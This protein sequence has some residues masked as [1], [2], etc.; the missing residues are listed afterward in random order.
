MASPAIPHS[1]H[2]ADEP[3]VSRGT[4][5]RYGLGSLGTGGFATLPGLVLVYYLTDTLGVSVAF[6]GLA[7]TLAKVWDVLIDPV[8]GSLSDR[9]AAKRGSRRFAMVLG[10]ITLPVFFA[11]TFAVPAGL[12]PAASAAWVMVSFLL[13][14]TAF[15]VFQVPYM[16]LPAELT[17][18]Y[19]T[20]TRLLTWRVVVLTIAILLFGAGGPEIRAL[21]PQDPHL[22][23]LIMGVVA[24]ITIGVGFF[25][26][27]RTAPQRTPTRTQPRLNL[28][29]SYREALEVIRESQPMRALLGAFALQALATG[30]MLAAAQYVAT[31]VLGDENGL[32]PLFLAL[33]AP[34]VCATPIW[35]AVSRRIG[36]ER[37]FM[38]AS[39]LFLVATLILI[40]LV[41]TPGWWVLAPVALAGCAYAGMQSLPLSM[42]PDVIQHDAEARGS[43]RAGV[44]SGVWTA[45]ETTGVAFGAG[46][47]TVILA[48]SGYVERSAT[49]ELAVTQTPETVTAIGL[50]FSLVPAIIIG[51]S[52]LVFTRYRLRRTDFEHREPLP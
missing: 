10:A 25:I 11:L 22:G 36:K 51:A 2:P 47:L 30:L 48:V 1:R 34:A 42:L 32:T 26:A 39:T 28:L 12:E 13:A 6:A 43:D 3:H 45:C 38:I 21:F 35:Q 18:D 50:A 5:L 19:D 33:I 8:I 20:K 46:L 14:A 24:G 41:V 29:A 37:T 52:M 49:S 16:A 31:W 40:A 4:L 7:I 15:S 23:Y 9:S 27:S 17:S 44:M